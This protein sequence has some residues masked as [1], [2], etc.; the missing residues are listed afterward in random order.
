M[1]QAQLACTMACVGIGFLAFFVGFVVG[2]FGC[3][4]EWLAY[5]IRNKAGKWVVN[6]T[7]GEAQFKLNNEK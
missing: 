4:Q 2:Y 3:R 6:E 7:T 1:D 5:C